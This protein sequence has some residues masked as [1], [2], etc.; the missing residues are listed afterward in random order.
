MREYR[1]VCGGRRIRQVAIMPLFEQLAAAQRVEG[2]IPGEAVELVSVTMHGP[3]T[4]QIVFRKFDG[5]LTNS[6]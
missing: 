3:D 5:S 6:C 4:A 2:V 1:L